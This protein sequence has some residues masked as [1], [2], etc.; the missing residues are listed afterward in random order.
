MQSGKEMDA[1]KP[2][3]FYT[4]GYGI[5]TGKHVDRREAFR[6]RLRN[7]QTALGKGLWIVDIRKK[8]SGSWNGKWFNQGGTG[9][10]PG[11]FITVFR[12][13]SIYSAE[14]DLSNEFGNTK[15]GLENYQKWLSRE[16]CEDGSASD[17]FYRVLGM[18][19]DAHDYRVVLLC[20]CRDAMGKRRHKVQ[21]EIPTG[22][23]NCHRVPL[24]KALADHFPDCCVVHL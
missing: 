21:G 14:P 8:G 5:L 6:K 1:V 20:S 15:R 17:A 13:R 24:G 16:L 9:S 11:M 22:R 7:L 19:E 18:I 3:V 2:I 12:T 10:N 4:M 23:A